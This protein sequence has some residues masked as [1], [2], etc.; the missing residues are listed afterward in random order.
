MGI[1]LFVL[2]IFIGSFLNVV[3][4]RLQK[5]ESFLLGR[6]YCPACKHKLSALDLVPLLSFLVLQ[7]KCRYC[8]AKI[9]WQYPLAELACG[10]FTLLLFLNFGLSLNF[11]VLFAFLCL[12]QVIFIVDAKHLIIPDKV[13]MPALVIGLVL[14]VINIVLKETSQST[15]VLPAS[16]ISALLGA[17]GGFIL[18]FLL[19]LVSKERWMGYG[20]SKLGA[21]IGLWLGWPNIVLVVFLSFMIGSVYALILMALGKKGFQDRIAFGPFLILAAVVTIFYGQQIIGWYSKIGY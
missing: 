14:V 10:L 13:A 15:L 17:F 3:A 6:S 21:I 11:V 8:K 1:I 18:Y 5:K 16:I 2:G 12:M 4:L 20:D 19:S 7:G 9:A